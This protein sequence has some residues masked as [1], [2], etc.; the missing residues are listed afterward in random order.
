MAFQNST[1][2]R[3]GQANLYESTIGTS[4]L[5]RIYT[6]AMPANPAAGASGTKLVEMTLPV[7]WLTNPGDGTKALLGTW[8]GTAI[9]TGTSGYF[10][11]YDSTGTTCGSQGTITLTGGGGDMTFDSVSITTGQSV[12]VVA[13]LLTMGNI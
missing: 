8:T 7:D 4:P 13:Y 6:G 10:R 3:A 9:A 11:L 2:I 12:S 1:A 5:Y